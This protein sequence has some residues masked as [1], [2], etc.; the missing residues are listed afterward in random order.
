MLRMRKKPPSGLETINSGQPWSALDVA[1]DELVTHRVPVAEMVD[2][3]C[4]DVEEVE[5][6]IAERRRHQHHH[7]TLARPSGRSAL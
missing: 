2:F 7:V 6:K 1:L 3:L 4:R 5:A